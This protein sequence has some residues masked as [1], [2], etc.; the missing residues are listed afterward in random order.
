M[1]RF[2]SRLKNLPLVRRPVHAEAGHPPRLL[3][4]IVPREVSTG[5]SGL[6]LARDRGWAVER[7]GIARGFVMRELPKSEWTIH[8]EARA[9]FAKKAAAKRWTNRT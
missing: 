2:G 5:G 3:L 9:E 6:V 1:S 4:P 7:R 8:M